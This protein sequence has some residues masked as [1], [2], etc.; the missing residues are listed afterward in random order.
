[1]WYLIRTKDVFLVYGGLNDEFGVKG[2]TGASFKTDR[3]DTKSQSGYLFIMNGGVVAWRSSK[4][5][6]IAM[7]STKAEYIVVSEVAQV[8]Y[9]MKKFI[10]ELGLVPSIKNPVKSE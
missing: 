1:M 3:D 9:W 6:T 8:A 4:Q 7:S 10:E 2:Y 5:D